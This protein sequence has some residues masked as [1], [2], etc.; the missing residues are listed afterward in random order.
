MHKKRCKTRPILMDNSGFTLIEIIAVLVIL[1]ILAVV[2][3]PRYFDLQSDAQKSAIE[4]AMAEVI[5]R[6]NGHF[7]KELLSGTQASAI[8]YTTATLTEPDRTPGDMG[9][10]MFAV[11]SEGN[12]ITIT[13]SGKPG[14]KTEK[15]DFPEEVAER[16]IPKPGELTASQPTPPTP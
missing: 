13:I 14:T 4:M 5:G 16:E 2:A 15:W 11:T 10:F 7:A 6:V 3:V 12:D 9:D 1:S 8:E